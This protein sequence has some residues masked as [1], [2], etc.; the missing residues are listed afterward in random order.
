[1]LHMSQRA[2]GFNCTCDSTGHV[3][4]TCLHTVVQRT[5]HTGG[6]GLAYVATSHQLAKRRNGLPQWTSSPCMHPMRVGVYILWGS[7]STTT[8]LIS[9]PHSRPIRQHDSML[10]TQILSTKCA[11]LQ[12]S[13]LTVSD[14]L[15]FTKV[16]T[17]SVPCH[18]HLLCSQY[19]LST[20]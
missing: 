17:L 1:M 16:E 13:V 4:L 8:G 11:H 14:S 12:L 10:L 18:I 15:A 7:D 2:T 5:T 3:C 6:K 9:W 19:L 20:L